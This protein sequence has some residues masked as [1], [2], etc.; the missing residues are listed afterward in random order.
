MEKVTKKLF[1]MQDLKARDF[2]AKIIN[3]DKEKMI[4]IKTPDIRNFVKEFLKDDDHIKFL[5]EL[6]H[7]YYEENIVHSSLLTGMKLDF[8]TFIDYLEKYLPHIDNWAACDVI[9]P[10]IFKKYPKEVLNKIK[11]WLKSKN[12]FTVRF[13]I[14]SLL[15][16]YLDENFSEEIF[17]L[18][19]SVES[20]EYY[21]NIA[22]AWFY[23][24]ALIKQYE[25]TLPI[26]ESKKL[27]KWI[28]NKSIQ[29]AV[30][31]FRVSD[32][33]KTYLRTLKIK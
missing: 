30:E 32:E 19:N 33:R 21:I 4:G 2:G 6:P 15:Q 9:S 23:S 24:F 12:T 13:G 20:E 22:I 3:I 31:S 5:E 11:I 8:K 14:V 16:F 18:V 17:D 27:S 10:K 1:E 7:K 28:Q 29:K 25:K 26:I